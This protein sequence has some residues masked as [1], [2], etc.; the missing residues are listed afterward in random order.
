M[1]QKQK[2]MNGGEKTQM[3]TLHK[4]RIWVGIRNGVVS[5][6]FCA[7][8]LLSWCHITSNSER[9]LV[10]GC[11]SADVRAWTGGITAFFC[12][13]VTRRQRK[14]P[15]ASFGPMAPGDR[16]TTRG[17]APCKAELFGEGGATFIKG[18]LRTSS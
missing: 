5:R 2:G 3:K 13:A 6:G 10:D 7:Q 11:G 12:T 9:G 4:R 17:R 15:T 18:R 8:V 16:L 14:I 1:G